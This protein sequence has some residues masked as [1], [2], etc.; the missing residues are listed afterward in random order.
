MNNKTD[1]FYNFENLLQIDSDDNEI[2]EFCKTMILDFCIGIFEK[3]PHIN[4]FIDNR[5]KSVLPFKNEFHLY[6]S[7]FDKNKNMMNVKFYWD[8]TDEMIQGD[9]DIELLPS[10]KNI[11]NKIINKLLSFHFIILFGEIHIL[12]ETING[13]KFDL[14]LQNANQYVA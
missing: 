11:Y 9:S 13:K 2:Y 10:A 12:P 14:I 7:S 5:L 1:N 8:F 4:K 3:C 6:F